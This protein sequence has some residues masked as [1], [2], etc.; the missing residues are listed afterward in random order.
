MAGRAGRR[1]AAFF[2]GENTELTAPGEKSQGQNATVPGIVD[3]ERVEFATRGDMTEKGLMLRI[4]AALAVMPGVLMW[5]NNV[6]I[7]TDKGVK[8]GLGIGSADLIGL[9][10]H[11]GGRFLAFEVKLPKYRRRV[12][13]EQKR[14]L[15]V[16]ARAGGVAAVVCSPEE[17]C[18][19]IEN[20][21]VAR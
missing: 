3:G 11:Q 8:Y 2:C 1:D 18:L 19:V 20:A 17:A 10:A 15:D 5:R 16:V 14:W 6:G 13:P 9:D 12:R 4:R 7:D 21:R